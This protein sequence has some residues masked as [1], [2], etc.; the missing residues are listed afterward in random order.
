[1]A[2]SC[3]VGKPAPK[4]MLIDLNRLEQA[5]V[6]GRPGGL[7]S[8]DIGGTSTG[9]TRSARSWL[10][11]TISAIRLRRSSHVVPITGVPGTRLNIGLHGSDA[12][13]KFIVLTEL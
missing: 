8:V 3:L 7:G 10:C 4:E 2:L 12:R 9:K 5:Y 6:A 1:M 13:S 11:V